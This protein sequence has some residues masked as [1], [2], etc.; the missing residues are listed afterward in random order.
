M[1]EVL[2]LQPP[3]YTVK[4]DTDCHLPNSPRRGIIYSN[5]S[6][7]RRVWLVTSRLGTGKSKTCMLADGQ[8]HLTNSSQAISVNYNLRGDAY[9]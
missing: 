1:G 6:R 8:I 3:P 4:K 9:I 5:Y 2:L 7:P